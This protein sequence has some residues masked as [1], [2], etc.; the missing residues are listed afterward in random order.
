M[1]IY[2]SL[3]RSK[4][5]KRENPAIVLAS[6]F[7]LL[8]LSNSVTA[9]KGVSISIVLFFLETIFS[10]QSFYYSNFQIDTNSNGMHNCFFSARDIAK[11]EL[12]KVPLEDYGEREPIVALL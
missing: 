6:L 10:N 5:S 3:D 7:Y 8:F 12:E 2:P 4:K 11:N 9:F 1:K